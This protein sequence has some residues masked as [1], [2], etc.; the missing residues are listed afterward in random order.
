[1]KKI[2][3][4]LLTFIM[5]ISSAAFVF[6]AEETS[7]GGEKYVYRDDTYD[8]EMMSDPMDVTDEEF[9][10]VWDAES[11]SWS[12]ESWFRYDEFP[13][14][15]KVESAVKN[16]DYDKAKEELRKYY[17]SRKDVL[18]T[19][20]GVN[21]NDADRLQAELQARNMYAATTTG[22][23][24]E[25]VPGVNGDWQV[26]SS[27]D[28]LAHVRTAV[29]SG[30]PY[31]SF[32]IASMD[33]SNTAAEIKGKGTDAP[34]TL[35]L[36]VNRVAQTLPVYE[37]AYI[38]P[39]LN[40]NTN[41]GDEEIL[42]AQEYGY[43]GHWSSA[44][45]PWGDEAAETKRTYIKF[46]ISSLTSTDTVSTAELNFTARVEDG[47]DLTEKEL[48][49]Y[50]WEDASWK[51]STITWNTFSDW[52][53]LSCNDQEAWDFYSNPLATE[54]GKLCYFLRGTLPMS[55]A[56]MYDSTGDEKYAYTFIRQ[57][58]SMINHIGA[59]KC[60]KDNHYDN[61]DK[62]PDPYR[63]MSHLDVAGYLTQLPNAF[64]LLW[65]S[66]LFEDDPSLFTAIFKNFIEVADYM[67]KYI[68]EKEV[69]T[70]NMATA[71][72]R[73]LYLLCNLFPEIK[74]TDYYYDLVIYHN[75]RMLDHIVYDDGACFTASFNY[76]GTELGPF[77]TQLT[78]YNETEDKHFGLPYDDEAV[79]KIYGM[80]KN[81]FYSTAPG[82]GGFSFA[83]SIDHGKT[84]VSEF[85]TRYNQLVNMGIDDEELKYVA[86]NGVQGKLPDIT[87]ISFPV[88][89]RTYMRTGWDKNAI[90]L[91]MIA[92]GD[93][94]SHR[95]NDQMSVVLTAYGRELLV[96]P[97]YASILTDD[98]Y[99]KVKAGDHHNTITVNG[100]NIY[101]STGQDS[102]VKAVEHN[103]LYDH[104]TYTYDYVQNAAHFERS[105]LFPKNQKFFII[106]D[107]V[108][109]ADTTK[110]NVFTQHWHMIPTSNVAITENNE[111]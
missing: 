104:V 101:G 4:L 73:S 60:G 27:K 89:K 31:V 47:G 21:V 90:A 32:V 1:M 22:T 15:E 97:A 48:F 66:K 111:F 91:A 108:L 67:C 37:D 41:Y 29:K 81:W 107:Y 94:A 99:A 86:T 82:W 76:I 52:L 12:T 77:T 43:V 72:N 33:K 42:Y 30:N 56:R 71:C 79:Q 14:M 6:A 92:K 5:L 23:P 53:F 3:C 63:G 106:A 34:P 51:E 74:Q 75:K 96:D 11:Q 62:N 16:G 83:D 88:A 2:I 69:T 105:V 35:T 18:Y 55:V 7:E 8:F 84:F 59:N 64:V 102:V 61:S 44:F 50:G 10:G 109:A 40:A 68:V 28:V 57:M 110:E 80:I 93:N 98:K 13:E 38:S 65:E 95:H 46:D 100:G 17:I 70:G 45:N 39:T 85:R 87:S 20:S 19:Q 25:I 26:M 24:I 78:Y 9:F 36:V 103:N 49:V 54:K 58:M